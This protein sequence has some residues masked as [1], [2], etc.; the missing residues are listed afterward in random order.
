[1]SNYVLIIKRSK[2]VNEQ[3]VGETLSG[4]HCHHIIEHGSTTFKMIKSNCFV[5]KMTHFMFQ[6]I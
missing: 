2:L 5:K 4:I 3:F 1:M 6:R